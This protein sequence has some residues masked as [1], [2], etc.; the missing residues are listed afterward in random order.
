MP[1]VLC[2]RHSVALILY[3]PMCCQSYNPS[4]VWYG[5][6]L[7]YSLKFCFLLSEF[8]PCLGEALFLFSFFLQ[9]FYHYF[10]WN[11]IHISKICSS[12]DFAS[13]KHKWISFINRGLH[14]TT[15]SCWV[16]ART[17]AARWVPFVVLSNRGS[18]P[19]F[20]SK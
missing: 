17:R 9:N 15:R 14:E 18:R 19:V 11:W 2:L 8:C 3:K 6:I 4:M 12:L 1:D 10:T 7:A 5:T 20:S 13:L 16:K